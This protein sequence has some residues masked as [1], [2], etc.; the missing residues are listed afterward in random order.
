MYLDWMR[1]GSLERVK[2]E[3]RKRNIIIINAVIVLLFIGI[4]IIIELMRKEILLLIP[5]GSSFCYGIDSFER[6][7][8][9]LS[10]KGWFIEFKNDEENH[11]NDSEDAELK[12]AL[13]PNYE[14]KA[15]AKPEN[16]VFLDVL[17]FKESRSDVNEYFKCDYDY[18]KCGFT[19]DIDVKK[20]DLD[21]IDYRLVIKPNAKKTPAVL[22]NVYLTNAGLSYTNPTQT[23][24]L[25]T[26]DTDL[27]KIVNEG[28]RLVSRPDYGCYIFQLGDELYW[29][30]DENFIFSKD[31]KTIVQLKMYTTQIENNAIDS[32]GK[33][34]YEI[35]SPD[36]FE[37]H[38]ITDS[39]NCGK[40]RVSVRVIPKDHSVTSVETGY[41]DGG[42]IWREEFKINYCKMILDEYS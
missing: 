13:V 34:V 41:Y 31:E 26:A 1:I 12:M 15:D 8:D 40:Y 22:L 9:I 24:G 18:S 19:A 2:M 35:T 16:A 5:D 17:S 37:S 14:A 42:W 7:E 28:I 29:I 33:N 21:T 11:E 25:D 6:K 27:D 32:R 10:I 36:Y 38:E 39:M 20:L 23:P 4:N 3:K 30:A